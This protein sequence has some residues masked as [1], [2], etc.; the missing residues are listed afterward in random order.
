MRS[1]HLPVLLMLSL[2]AACVTAN[3][4]AQESTATST[5][6]TPRDRPY[7]GTLSLAVDLTD[8]R[9]KIFR[10]HE[11]IPVRAGPLVLLYPKWIPGEHG[12]TGTL[13]G[14]TGLAIKAGGTVVPW[15]RDLKEMFALHLTVPAGVQN[16]D[17]DFEF[18]STNAE[19]NFGQ[20]VSV[21]ENLVDLE[22]N[23]VLF[24]PAGTYARRIMFAPKVRVPRDWGSATALATI[25]SDAG[26]IAFETVDLETLIDSPLITGKNFR[27]VELTAG[28]APRV[29]LNIVADRP[30]NPQASDTQIQSLSAVVKEATALFGAH[31][32]RH[33]D[34]LLTLSDSTGHFGLEHHESSDDRLY[35]DFF[36]D[37]DTY[38]ATATLLPHEYLHSWN[39]KFRRP[40][41]LIIPTYNEPMHGDLLWVY[42]GLTDYWAPVLTARSGTWNAD[43]LQGYLAWLISNVSL[44]PGHSWRPLQDTADEAQI[45]YQE[46][47]AWRNERRL[48]D[49]YE[50]G[51]LL[52]LDVDVRIRELSN[53][54]HSLDDFAKSFHG[55]QDG[56]IATVGYQFGDI[57][58]ALNHV[59]AY[60]WATFLRSRLNATDGETAVDGL[61]RGGWKLVYTDQPTGYFKSRMK[62]DKRS[63]DMASIGLLVSDKTEAGT[64]LDVLWGGPA[65]T[66]G[67]APGMVVVAVNGQK[68][69]S[70]I[71][72]DAIAAT[73]GHGTPVE[74]LLRDGDRFWTA[75]LNYADGLRYPH[76]ERI[77][78]K[79]DLLSEIMKSRR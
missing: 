65:F 75:T 7:P 73:K 19:G 6:P 32:Y 17:V 43:Q 37:P 20:S 34:F 28:T 23:Q 59:Q 47:M 54:K 77:E 58:A 2:A 56:S 48:T 79:P 38:I 44:T 35:A 60:D 11:T 50:E 24:Y 62:V 15:R 29:W 14:V 36:T 51:S 3:S 27:R 71:L 53:G 52:W 70:E 16:L 42:E 76:L 64:I 78:G 31:H 69:D 13:D 41:G 8:A 12:P 4:M 46:G 55:I 25:H 39:G 63:D 22:W 67:I 18:L 26:E 9:Q 68:Y 21:T 1:K 5:L 57:V 30:E 45:L 10:I 61:N 66:A 72:Q 40:A 33:Y 49:F 74:L